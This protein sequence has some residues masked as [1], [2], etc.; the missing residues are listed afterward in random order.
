MKMIWL[1]QAL[2]LMLFATTP[3]YGNGISFYAR[4]AVIKND[5]IS[6]DIPDKKYLPISQK[7]I[8]SCASFSNESC[9]SESLI[10]LQN[11]FRNLYNANS[12]AWKLFIIGTVHFEIRNFKESL[13]AYKQTL[14]YVSDPTLKAATLHRILFIHII[15]RE[16]DPAIKTLK[17]IQDLFPT[18][19][20]FDRTFIT[21]PDSL[22]DPAWLACTQVPS[23][24]EIISFKPVLQKIK[25]IKNER[26]F[27]SKS[28]KKKLAE[29]V[30]TSVEL[31]RL[32]EKICPD[33]T[34]FNTVCPD[35][36]MIYKE[37]YDPNS[38]I[39]GMD[40]ALLKILQSH[41]S[42]EYEGDEIAESKDI[43]ELYGQF[44]EKFPNSP[45]SAEIKKQY[46]RSK[47]ILSEHSK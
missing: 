35:A 42:Y 20:F 41:F 45:L 12:K 10:L 6:F 36:L 7:K 2:V 21:Y 14:K 17:T 11:E 26:E 29:Y 47:K 24:Q 18:H 5:S 31:G 15:L 8:L 1:V 30:K 38:N 40:Y 44:L 28:K 4:E 22:C 16:T 23:I 33:Q 19:N 39:E 13:K 25:R 27:L 9:I 3:A 34:I 46:E 43:V 37:V 32:Y